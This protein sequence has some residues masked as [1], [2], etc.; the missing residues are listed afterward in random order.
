MTVPPLPVVLRRAA[1]VAVVCAAA[2]SARAQTRIEPGR[3]FLLGGEQSQP[4]RVEGRNTGTVPVELL[5]RWQDRDEPVATVAP[6]APFAFGLPP[7][8][9]AMARNPGS[10]A[11]SLRFVFDGRIDRLSM[12]YDR[13]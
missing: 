2:V 13:P 9:I 10:T 5:V 7:G 3:S 11:A 8:A 1:V 4:V 6:G 12:R